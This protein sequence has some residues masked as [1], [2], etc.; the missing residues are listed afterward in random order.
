MNIYIWQSV[1]KCT[2]CY[3]P[4]GGVIVIAETEAQARE[5][6]NAKPGCHIR[7]DEMP[8]HVRK[9]SGHQMVV[10]FPDAGCC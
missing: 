6:A 5:F 1:D 8:D 2:D 9:V 7:E 10:V 3:H 4:E